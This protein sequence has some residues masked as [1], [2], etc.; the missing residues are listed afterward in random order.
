MIEITGDSVNVGSVRA[1]ALS[2]VEVSLSSKARETMMRS[3]RYLM[4]RLNRGET[5]Y[6]VNTGFGALS[7]VK[8]AS[9]DIDALQ[10]NIIRSHSSGVG[11]LFSPQETRA[12]IFL[13][14]NALARGHSGIRPELV[15][16]LLE[17]LKNN[18]LPVIPQ[19]GSVGASGDLAPLAHLALGLIG[20]GECWTPDGIKLTSQVLKE[21]KIEPIKLQAKEGLSLI[22]GCQVMTAVGILTATKAR[23]LALLA[24]VSGAMSLEA[25][26]GSRKAFDGIISLARPH[27]GEAQTA[28]NLR[29]ILGEASQIGDSHIDCKRVQ[30]SYSLRCMPAVHG[31]TKNTIR[32]TLTTLEIEANSSTDNPLVFSDENKILS[33]GNFHGEPVAFAMDYLGIAMTALGS[34]SERRIEKMINVNTSGLPAFLAPSG[35]LHSG[36]MIVQ[37]AAASLVSENQVLSHPASVDTIPTSAGKEDHV[38]MGT[39][40]ARKCGSI[41]ENVKNIIAMEVLSAAQALDFHKPLK[42]TAGVLAAYEFVRKHVPFAQEDRVFSSDIKKVAGLIEDGSLLAAVESKVG[43]L[44][45]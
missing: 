2:G 27:Y 19:Q 6:G 43:Q 5:I 25:L 30:D 13:R 10:V 15:E 23:N 41:V 14:A 11:P 3:R 17:Y 1:V 44:L 24:D 37:Y 8:I 36:H 31:A 9:N 7:D 26:K 32:N 18:I 45:L 33:C 4:E 40:A 20:E 12:I 29:K 21:K 38:S 22:N 34:M 28:Q 42:P 35:G 16:K 39:I